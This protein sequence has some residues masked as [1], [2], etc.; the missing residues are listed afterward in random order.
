MNTAYCRQ[1]ESQVLHLPGSGSQYEVGNAVQYNEEVYP[2]N[3]WVS[4]TKWHKWL[5]SHLWNGSE[6]DYHKR[7][8]LCNGMSTAALNSLQAT[9]AALLKESWWAL[10]SETHCLEDQWAE[11]KNELNCLPLTE[12]HIRALDQAW[13]SEPAVSKA[14]RSLSGLAAAAAYNLL[15]LSSLS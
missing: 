14:G 11:S 9:T 13:D 4:E 12:N 15:W 8:A 2:L 7:W 1:S 5:I 10:L 6:C 3:S